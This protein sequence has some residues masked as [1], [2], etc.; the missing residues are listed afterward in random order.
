MHLISLYKAYVKFGSLIVVF[1]TMFNKHKKTL[2]YKIISH[3]VTFVQICRHSIMLWD[4]HRLFWAL[5]FPCD[6][7]VV[8]Q[9]LGVILYNIYISPHVFSHIM[10]LKFLLGQTTRCITF[11]IIQ[12]TDYW[13]TMIVDA[14]VLIVITGKQ[15]NK[16]LNF[17]M[18]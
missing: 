18:F 11:I 4:C 7:C 12:R 8:Q 13:T 16:H 2:K 6:N 5:W 17:H 14:Y 1:K 10:G 3:Y 15:I 9:G